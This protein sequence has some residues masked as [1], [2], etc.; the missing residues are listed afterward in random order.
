MTMEWEVAP[1]ED[2]KLLRDFLRGRGMTASLMR[3]IKPAGGFFCDGA[4]LHTNRRI[5]AGQRVS[6]ALPPEPPTPVCPQDLPLC[7]VY[8]DRHAMLLDKPSGMTTHPTTGCPDG[9]LA[10]AFRGEMVKRGSDVPFRPINRLDRG[11]SGLVLCALNQYAAPLLAASAQKIYYAV[12]EGILPD[13]TGEID[14]P[15]ARAPDSIISRRTAPDGK[16]SRTAYTVLSRAGG[17]TLLRVKPYTGR[18]HQIRV[19]FAH[20][21]HPLAGDDLYG[22]HTEYLTHP[23]LHC[24]EITFLS[25]ETNITRTVRAPFP[26]DLQAFLFALKMQF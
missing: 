18:T 19:H 15:I 22:G 4:P 6:F 16:P 2:G 12:A 13:D 23:A 3:S 21:G 10:N 26:P 1:Q 9:T 24:G 20:I 5:A 25:P 17:H 14:A 11:V 8:E 7:I